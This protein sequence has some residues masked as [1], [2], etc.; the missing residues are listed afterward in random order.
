MNM[1]ES[2]MKYLKGYMNVIDEHISKIYKHC[3][4]Y[5]IEPEVCAYYS[6]WND[7]CS[8]WCDDIGMTRT[9]A[10]EIYHGGKGEFLTFASGEI[11]RFII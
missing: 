6:N 10:K 11:I 5:N 9:E 2:S 1:S 8:D 7:F 3:E 4:K